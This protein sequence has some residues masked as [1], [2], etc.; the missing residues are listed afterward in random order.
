MTALPSPA[1]DEH[2]AGSPDASTDALS[3][4]IDE[5]AALHRPGKLNEAEAA[6]RAILAK[7]P[8]HPDTLHLLGYLYHQMDRDGESAAYD[9][10]ESAG[11]LH[12]LDDTLSGWRILTDLLADGSLMKIGLYSEA[13]RRHIVAAGGYAP[14]PDGIRRCRQDILALPA[15]DIVRKIV[16]SPDFY[17]L[18]SFRDLIFHVYEHHFTL[19]ALATMLDELGLEFLGFELTDPAVLAKY[20]S[21]FPDDPAALDLSNWARFEAC[22]PDAFAAIY[23]FWL[24]KPAGSAGRPVLPSDAF[25]WA[26]EVSDDEFYREARLVTHI[27]DGAIAAMTELYRERLP[28]GGAILDLMSSWVS[29]LPDDVRFGRV[30]GLGMNNEELAATPV[31]TPRYARISIPTRPCLLPMV[32]STPSR[33]ASRPSI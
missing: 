20:R 24:R 13:A 21:E 3:P 32:S 12:H 9:I 15:N 16:A 26:D 33:S 6:Y 17:N 23:Q 30:V 28:K 8:N 29:H 18:S 4:Q 1:P 2:A 19:P 14:T 22:I 11:V 7:T 25:R 31:S 10:I 5:A 27:D